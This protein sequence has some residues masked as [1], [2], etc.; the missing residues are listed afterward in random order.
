MAQLSAAAGAAAQRAARVE[1]EVPGDV[2]IKEGE[3]GEV[4]GGIDDGGISIALVD[5]ISPKARGEQAQGGQGIDGRIR[6]RLWV[7]GVAGWIW[8]R[9]ELDGRDF[10]LKGLRA[11]LV[12]RGRITTKFGFDGRCWKPGWK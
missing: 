3:M 12:F 1:V 10:L 7:D 8:R 9:H 2:T 11:V 6:R 5:M 4:G